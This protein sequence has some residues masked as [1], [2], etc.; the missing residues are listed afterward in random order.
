MRQRDRQSGFSATVILLA[1][2]VVAVVAVAGFAVFQHNRTKVSN[3]AAS[4]NQSTNPLTKTQQPTNT[5]PAPTVSYLIVKEWGVKVPLP[6]SIKDA[7][8][9]PTTGTHKG[10][11][12]QPDQLSLGFA[13]LDSSGCAVANGAAP[14]LLFRVSPTETDPVSGTPISQEGPGTTIGNYFYGY[15]LTKS[16]TCNSATTFQNLDSSMTTAVK[17]IVTATAN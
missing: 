1:V 3:A 10:P 7:Y 15:S 5:S 14:V 12:G 2:L 6:D 13:S 8:Y 17:G 16:K 4:T 11:D 9:A